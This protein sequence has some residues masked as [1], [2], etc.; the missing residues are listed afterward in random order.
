M[1]DPASISPQQISEAVRASVEK[2]LQGRSAAFTQPGHTVGFVAQPPHWVGILY[3]NPKIP[4]PHNIDTKAK[5]PA[6]FSGK[7]DEAQQLADDIAAAVKSVQGLHVGKPAVV[8][9]RDHV[10]IGFLPTDAPRDAVVG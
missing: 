6:P 10:T 1:A 2:V 3:N 5:I 4:I 7:K 8:R 9:G